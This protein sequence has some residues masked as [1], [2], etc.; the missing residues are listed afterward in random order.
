MAEEKKNFGDFLVGLGIITADQLIKALQEQKRA[1]GR[2][3][4][5]II[6]LQYAKEET[7]FQGLADYFNLPF[8]DLNTYL[9]DEELPQMIPEEMARRHTLIPLFKIGSTLTV[10]MVNP[11]NILALDE[12]RNKTKTDVEIA[13]STEEKIR[14]AIDQHYGSTA[15]MLGSTHLQYEEEMRA[16]RSR[17]LRIIARPTIWLSKN[18]SR[19]PRKMSRRPGCST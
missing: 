6:R 19:V 11:L 17:S 1:G 15:T 3:E 16:S 18:F 14:K 2:L 7:V 5:T 8:V 10:A 12:V 13:I 4:Q 9:I